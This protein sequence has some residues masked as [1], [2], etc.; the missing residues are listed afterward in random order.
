MGSVQHLNVR[1]FRKGIQCGNGIRIIRTVINDDQLYI[2]VGLRLDR[3][4]TFLNVA[5]IVIAGHNDTHHGIRIH[6]TVSFIS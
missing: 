2:W 6:P 5:A 1:F 3:R 4:N